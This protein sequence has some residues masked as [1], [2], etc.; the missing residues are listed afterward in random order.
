MRKALILGLFITAFDFAFSQTAPVL[1]L[2]SKSDLSCFGSNDGKVVLNVVGGTG[3]LVYSLNGNTQ[4]SNTYSNLSV[5]NYKFFVEDSVGN[6]DSIATS[7]GEPVKIS[8]QFSTTHP[9][10][11]YKSDGSI[12]TTTAGGTGSKQ[13]VWTDSAGFSASSQNINYLSEGFYYLSVTDVNGCKLDTSVKLEHQ[14]KLTLTV[15]TTDISCNGLS[16]GT[17][18]VNISGTGSTYSQTWNGPNSF[19]STTKKITG[20]GAGNYGVK[21]IESVSGCSALI[22]TNI[23]NPTKLFVEISYKRHLLAFTLN[24]YLCSTD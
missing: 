18:E 17:A 7:I 20:L 21:V 1:S 15:T 6:K 5:G 10:C 11:E 14:V 4:T 22:S 8:A 19:T 24:S 12:L 2:Q 3:P 13:F 16:N 9:S 23:V